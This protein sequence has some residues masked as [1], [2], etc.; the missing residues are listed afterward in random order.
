M[1]PS[2]GSYI[3]AAKPRG[4]HRANQPSLTSLDSNETDEAS[5]IDQNANTWS[6]S[7]G[8]TVLSVGRGN[9]F[10]ESQ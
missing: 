6:V 1:G 5:T 2:S 7:S 8:E 9:L 3:V 4:L 10:K